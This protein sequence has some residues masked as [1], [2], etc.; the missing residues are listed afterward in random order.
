MGGSVVSLS[1]IPLNHEVL[2][3]RSG[4]DAGRSPS[5]FFPGLFHGWSLAPFMHGTQP[6]DRNPLIPSWKSISG[7]APLH[8]V[9]KA[10]Q[11]W[12]SPQGTD[13]EDLQILV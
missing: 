7:C 10:A 4:A 8:E 2:N 13:R 5:R 9:S 12:E 1:L 6:I 11:A 3:R